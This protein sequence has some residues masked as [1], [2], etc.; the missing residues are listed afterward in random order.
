M[1]LEKMKE[2]IDLQLQAN[3]EHIEYGE[4]SEEIMAKIDAIAEELTLMEHMMIIKIL[5]GIFD[6]V[7][8]VGVEAY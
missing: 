3:V 6:K 5:E 2:M 7:D 1:N 4:P 8:I